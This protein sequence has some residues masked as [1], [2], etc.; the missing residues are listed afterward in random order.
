[1]HAHQPAY[2]LLRIL[3]RVVSVRAGLDGA[4]VDADKRKL[5][6]VLVRHD[7][8]NQPAKRS[9]RIWR[10]R[11]FVSV[12]GVHPFDWRNIERRRQIIHHCIEQCLHTFVL[13]CRTRNHGHQSQFDGP[14]A[15]SFA[16]LVFADL[17][18]FDVLV[19]QVIVDG[20]YRFD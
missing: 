7:L 10:P 15:H 19:H 1:V 6:Q 12:L 3:G 18:A 16:N 20:S 2:P 8:E 11:L 5:A 17:L 9:A 13:K 14:F 4:A